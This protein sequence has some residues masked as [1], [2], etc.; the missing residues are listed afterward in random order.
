[1]NDHTDRL[2]QLLD[3]LHKLEINTIEKPN[4]T[5]TKMPA[6]ILAV[7]DI[8]GA[9]RGQVMAGYGEAAQHADIEAGARPTSA[10]LASAFIDLMNRARDHKALMKDDLDEDIR[11]RRII[12]ARIAANC[13]VVLGILERNAGD[14]A[15]KAKSADAKAL[16]GMERDALAEMWKISPSDRA[17]IRKI[18]EVGTESVLMQTVI[19]IEGDVIT[20]MNSAVARGRHPEIVEV[21]KQSIEISLRMWGQLVDAAERLL[22]VAGSIVASVVR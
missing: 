8:Y 7:H 21:H 19:Q 12:F 17:E 18:W 4:L 5:A 16:R 9:Y 2:K 14:M 22:K 3:D 6:P 20:R 10:V 15:D 11:S 1:M 13:E